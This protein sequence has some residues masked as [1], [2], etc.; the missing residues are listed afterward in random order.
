MDRWP[1]P[2]EIWIFPAANPHNTHLRKDSVFDLVQHDFKGAAFFCRPHH[3][4][5][6]TVTK[7]NVRFR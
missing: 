2:I 1:S 7:L 6:P 5:G 3:V 4:D